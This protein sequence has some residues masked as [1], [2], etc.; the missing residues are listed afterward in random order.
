[1]KPFEIPTSLGDVRIELS[2]GSI[3]VWDAVGETHCDGWATVEDIAEFLREKVHLPPE[4]AL[5]VAGEAVRRW[6]EWLGGRR[7]SY[8]RESN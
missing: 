5:S 1:M 8:P 3:C 7:H 2:D 6:V 4:E